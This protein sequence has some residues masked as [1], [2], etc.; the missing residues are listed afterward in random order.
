[1]KLSSDMLPSQLN[2]IISKL[3]GP[4]TLGNS[5]VF[6]AAFAVGLL[7]L[8]AQPIV[9]GSYAAGQFSLFLAYGLLGLSL[10]LIWG[11]A[12]ILSFG[13]VAFFGIA[14]Y[15]YA[16]VSLNLGG[17]IGPTVALPIAIAVA[18]VSAFILGYFMFY[19]GVRNVYVAILTLVVTL[20]L[21]TFMA[22]TAGAQW[23]IGSVKLGGFNG[24][25][26]VQNFTLGVGE[27]SFTLSG[28]RFYWF[29]L[30]VLLF[31][32]LGSRVLVNS[33]YGY[34][35]VAIREDEERTA[36]LGYN[37]K[38]VKLAVFTFAGALAGLSGI[39]YANWGNYVDPSVFSLTFATIPIVWVTLGGRESLLGA[40][41]GTVIIEWL[42]K[43]FSINASEFAIVFVG[44][45]LMV[46][47]LF[48][49]RGILPGIK[50]MYVFL[51]THGLREGV[52]YGRD[53]IQTRVKT[54]LGSVGI[55]VS[56]SDTPGSS[57]VMRE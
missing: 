4:N 50:N 56:E 34:S 57:E 40:I 31:A 51:S 1:M 9:R 13:Q 16:V 14:G 42:R 12:G 2:G 35:L 43:W 22:Q 39:F 30:G 7:I 17:A 49:P 41:V 23:S 8:I 5:R 28:S 46:T 10:S 48:I 26:G 53:T 37:V 32:Y 19:G 36:M 52:E 45:I 21:E 47:I 18:T 3:N 25:P 33:K 29:V 27:S 44:L 6:W 11:Y 20:V 15:T 24:I 38:K 55:N 54:L